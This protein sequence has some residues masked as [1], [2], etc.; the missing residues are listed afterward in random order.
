M[1]KIPPQLFFVPSSAFCVCAACGG[2]DF[3]LFPTRCFRKC[4]KLRTDAQQGENSFRTQP[5]F[6]VLGRKARLGGASRLWK[7]RFRNNQQSL[8]QNESTN[9]TK[10]NTEAVGAKRKRPRNGALPRSQTLAK[11]SPL[12]HEPENQTIT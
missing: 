1:K 6:F 5:S 8:F 4:K 12:S 9:Y 11:E 3:E 10:A 2:K 7:R